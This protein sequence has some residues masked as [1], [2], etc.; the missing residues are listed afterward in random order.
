MRR[1]DVYFGALG[2]A[3]ALS[4]VVAVLRG[5]GV[6]VTDPNAIVP[7]VTVAGTFLVWRGIILLLVGWLF[8][9]N[10]TDGLDDRENQATVVMASLML[11][12]VAGADLLS[13]VLGAI[14]GGSDVWLA[15][16]VEVVAALG[17]PYGPA[18]LFAPLAL[19][20]LRYRHSSD[21]DDQ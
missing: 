12:I 17:P 18:L 9:S 5:V 6:S 13:R 7:L 11:W 21:G 19:V 20:A 16:P 1:D 15:G 10:V 8:L 3:V 14:P 4:G 2:L